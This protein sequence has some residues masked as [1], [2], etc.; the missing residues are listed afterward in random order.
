MRTRLRVLLNVLRGRSTAFR[1]N[2]DGRCGARSGALLM[3]ECR[4]SNRVEGNRVVPVKGGGV[5]LWQGPT[6]GGEG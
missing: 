6:A 2:I 5:T 4:L 1:L 3:V